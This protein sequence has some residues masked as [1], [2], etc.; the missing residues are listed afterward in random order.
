MKTDRK[1]PRVAR[2]PMRFRGR[3]VLRPSNT[4]TPPRTPPA[5]MIK[6]QRKES[7]IRPEYQTLSCDLWTL[8]K[9]VQDELGA[10]NAKNHPSKNGA[11]N[12]GDSLER[13][14]FYNDYIALRNEKLRKKQRGGDGEMDGPKSAYNLGVKVES[15]TKKEFKKKAE[16]LKKSAVAAAATCTVDR[17]QHPRYALRSTAKKPPLPLPMN[18]EENTTTVRKTAAG[19]RSRRM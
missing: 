4:N 11:T 1:P 9:M 6:T 2:S 7:E 5:T 18:D 16:N 19:S 13:G 17:S 12:Y 10:M 3:R 15:G 14:R 8:S